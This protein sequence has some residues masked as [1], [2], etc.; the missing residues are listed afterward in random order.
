MDPKNDEVQNRSE[1]ENRP[2]WPSVYIVYLYLYMSPNFFVPP[3]DIIRRLK[4]VTAII[5]ASPYNSPPPAL[6]HCLTKI[7]FGCGF[8]SFEVEARAARTRLGQ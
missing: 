1:V 3:R 5:T 8:S 6:L 2:A 4:H 7:E